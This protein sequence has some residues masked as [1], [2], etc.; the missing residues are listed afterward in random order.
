MLNQ[1]TRTDLFAFDVDEAGDALDVTLE[2]FNI[3]E[4]SKALNSLNN[5]K[6]H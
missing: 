5:D 1:P 4:T 2:V 6:A 3:T